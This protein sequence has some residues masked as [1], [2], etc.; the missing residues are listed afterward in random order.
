MTRSPLWALDS[1]CREGRDQGFP[2]DSVVKNPHANA[3]AQGL[4]PDSGRSHVPCLELRSPCAITV[5]PVP[6]S[7]GTVAPE[8]RVP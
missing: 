2:G 5:G 4:I 3:G 8:A 6:Y 1:F 7:L